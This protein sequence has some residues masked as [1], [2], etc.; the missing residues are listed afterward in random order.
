MKLAVIGT[1]QMGEA[2]LRAFAEQAM[3]A[4]DISVFDVDEAKAQTIAEELG[5][6][7]IRACEM[8][9]LTGH[10]ILL[11]AVKPQIMEL[12]VTQLLPYTDDN[13]LVI[14][15]AA[16]IS[17]EQLRTMGLKKNAL[18]RV[19]PNTP[20]LVNAAV[21]GIAYDQVSDVQKKWVN[22]L[23]SACGLVFEL[24][25]HLL[26]AVTGLSGSGP[27]YMMI[28]LEA[29]SDAGVQQGL[30]RDQA[31]K[32]AAMT[33]FGS[34]KMVLKTGIHPA[35]LKDQVCSPGG[36]TI[37]AVA[38]LEESGLRNAL[39]KAVAASTDKSRLLGRSSKGNS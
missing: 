2:L 27:A 13:T 4:G 26:D 32:M 7:L 17:L 24:P 38:S 1:G 39:I 16:G 18:V 25:E 19:M 14:S 3:D 11:L 29:M 15:I 9:R 10:D 21:C 22:D 30:S 31:L 20:A 36:T 6:N 8:D 35:R 34:A 12:A 37:D 5:C 23:F 33:M 28:I